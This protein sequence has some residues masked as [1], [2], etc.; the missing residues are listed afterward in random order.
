LFFFFLDADDA[1]LGTTYV[2]GH[3]I[4]DIMILWLYF[5]NPLKF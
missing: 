4:S 5:L 3:D 2:V 1:Q